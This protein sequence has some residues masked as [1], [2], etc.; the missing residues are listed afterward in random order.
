MRF[1]SHRAPALPSALLAAALALVPA[2][3]AADA[4]P[5]AAGLRARARL[6]AG[7]EG[8]GARLAAVEIAPDRGFKT[9]WR[10]PGESGLP[11]AFDWS[12]STNLRAIE[13]LWP[14]P[15]RFEDAG[16]V[17]Y[18]YDGGVVLPLRV[19]ASGRGPPVRW[20]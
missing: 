4:S 9:Y 2:A 13:V 5:W 6:L 20:R 1:S 10:H 18:G 19:R 7:G 16:G 3:A 15:H 17:S 8:D 12:G 14:A 11:P